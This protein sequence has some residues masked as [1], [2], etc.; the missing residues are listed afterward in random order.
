[1]QDAGLGLI[2]GNKGLYDGLDV[3]GSDSN[4]ALAKLLGAPVILVIDCE[5]MTRGIAPLILGYQAFDSELAIKGVIL[6]RVGGSRHEG[7]LRAALE[8]YTDVPVLGAVQRDRSLGVEERHLGLTTPAETDAVDGVIRRISTCVSDGIDLDTVLEIAES[9][10]PPRAQKRPQQGNRSNPDIRIAIARDRAFGFY[11][12]DDLEALAAARAE[13][14]PFDTLSDSALPDVDGVL[15]GG[16]FP[17][18]QMAG[19][20]ANASLRA[21]IKTALQA[22]LPA[23]AECGGLMYLCR[24]LAWN[25]E[26]REM[27]GAIPADAVMNARPQGRGYASLEER[28]ALPWPKARS[29]SRGMTALP[30]HEFHYAS[31]QNLPTETVFAYDVSRGVGIDGRHDGIVIGNLLAN[32]IHLRDT[33]AN[34]WTARFAAFVRAN[35]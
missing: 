29:G 28:P 15:F 9:A 3:A 14:V 33:A 18:T 30:A 12:A 10:P 19:L 11:Y 35:K 16:G 6:N 7:K 32:F 2:E 20:E 1:M 13:L 17:E 22:G 24:S 27:V 34:H 21:G 23:Y 31:L 25:G 5:G 4:A 26:R 8:R